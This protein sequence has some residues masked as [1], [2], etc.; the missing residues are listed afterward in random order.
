MPVSSLGLKQQTV[1]ILQTVCDFQRFS[2]WKLSHHFTRIAGD[3]LDY[4]LTRAF[5]NGKLKIAL[6]RFD[7]L[8]DFLHG[9]LQFLRTFLGILL[10]VFTC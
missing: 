3:D 10:R 1:C 9:G 4:Y 8:I 6:D 7:E 2:R 5:I